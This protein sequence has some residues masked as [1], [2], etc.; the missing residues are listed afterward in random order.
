LRI[1][2]GF[3]PKIALPEPFKGTIGHFLEMVWLLNQA[4]AELHKPRIS[5][6][7]PWRGLVDGKRNPVGI[8]GNL[9]SLS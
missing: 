7:S 9:F 4:D 2:D 3:L 5:L 1:F 8:C 6:I